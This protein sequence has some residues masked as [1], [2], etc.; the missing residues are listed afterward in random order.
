M[1]CPFISCKGK[2]HVPLID[3]KKANEK[4]DEPRKEAKVEEEEDR[5]E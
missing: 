1:C 3:K 4:A 5:E 2:K